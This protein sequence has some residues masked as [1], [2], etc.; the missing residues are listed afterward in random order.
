MI[1]CHFSQLSSTPFFW[2]IL[3]HE[4]YLELYLMNNS[5][6]VCFLACNLRHRNFKD[7]W[8]MHRTC[9]MTWLSW[10]RLKILVE[11]HGLEWFTPYIVGTGYFI[12]K[13]KKVPHIKWNGW[14]PNGFLWKLVT[15]LQTR[16]CNSPF[17]SP[18]G[19][20]EG[21]TNHKKRGIHVKS[22]QSYH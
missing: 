2:S 14:Y 10:Y 6:P 22:Y 15:K 13:T 20:K 9:Y 8:S 19:Y 7:F 12:K 5:L 11:N 4:F 3:Y 1:L 17:H 21:K 18:Q 16:L